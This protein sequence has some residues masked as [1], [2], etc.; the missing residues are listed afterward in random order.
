MP[1][2]KR[3][4]EGNMIRSV[5]IFLV[6]VST[7]FSAQDFASEFVYKI[8]TPIKKVDSL[9]PVLFILHGYGSNEEDLFGLAQTLDERLTIISVRAPTTL[10]KGSFCWFKL[11]RDNNQ[12]L[13]YN[14]KEV[15]E[16]RLALRKFIQNTCK[17]KH[18][19]STQVYLMG[20]SQGTMMSY[21]MALSYPGKFAGILAL[22]GRLM[23]ESKIQSKSSAIKTTNF[24]I[25]HGTEDLLIPKSEADLA[26]AYLK[27]RGVKNI[28]FNS[29]RMQHVLNGEDI[30]DIRVWLSKVLNQKTHAIKKIISEAFHTKKRAHNL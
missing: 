15:S 22:S 14:Y 29:Y 6:L 13:L 2:V 20:F 30:I 25:A 18:L 19:D 7:S 24:F 28:D 3:K 10:E 5:I 12:Q 21:D 27:E 9:S 1:Q 17:N 23:K 11:S 16:T 4:G 26:L 8:R